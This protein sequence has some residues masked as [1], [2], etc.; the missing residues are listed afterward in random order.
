MGTLHL[1]LPKADGAMVLGHHH[2]VASS[3]MGWTESPQKQSHVHPFLTGKDPAEEEKDH[4]FLHPQ[5]DW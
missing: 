2:F 3:P 1:Q 4:L 5:W